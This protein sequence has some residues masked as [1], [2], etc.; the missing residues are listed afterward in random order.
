MGDQTRSRLFERLVLR[1]KLR[2][3]GAVVGW[4]AHGRSVAQSFELVAYRLHPVVDLLAPL[5]I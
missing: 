5:A 3:E 1:F 4:A 2:D